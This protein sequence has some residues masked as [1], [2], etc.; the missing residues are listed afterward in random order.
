MD[1]MAYS[2]NGTLHVLFTEDLHELVE[3]TEIA[4]LHGQFHIFTEKRRSSG[5][6]A[7]TAPVALEPCGFYLVQ[8]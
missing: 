2:W 6:S 4:S 3:V 1:G 5:G 8:P 7:E